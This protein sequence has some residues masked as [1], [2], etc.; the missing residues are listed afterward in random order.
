MDRRLFLTLWLLLCVGANN[1]LYSQQQTNVVHANSVL[2]MKAYERK[3]LNALNQIAEA[4]LMLE[5]ER[6]KHF[7]GGR[8]HLVRITTDTLRDPDIQMEIYSYD[9]LK[10]RAIWIGGRISPKEMKDGVEFWKNKMSAFRTQN[11]PVESVRKIAKLI[12]NH[13]YISIGLEKISGNVAPKKGPI[14]HAPDTYIAVHDEAGIL[15]LKLDYNK[16]KDAVL[17][18]GWRGI[19]AELMRALNNNK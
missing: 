5:G 8:T 9:P 10:D 16:E 12:E 11:V 13:N 6:E 15:N 2:M 19:S 3:F 18:E 17:L 7:A 4:A 1:H 14:L